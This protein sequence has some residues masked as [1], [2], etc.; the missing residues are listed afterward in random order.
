MPERPGSGNRRD[1]RGDEFCRTLGDGSLIR[2]PWDRRK[3]NLGNDSSR[4]F[5]A[6]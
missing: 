4:G 1:G 3:A 6:V 5:T 2:A